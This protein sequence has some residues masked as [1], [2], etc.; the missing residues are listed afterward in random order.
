[1]R[2][3]RSGLLAEKCLCLMLFSSCTG[4]ASTIHHVAVEIGGFQRRN[5]GGPHV[6]VHE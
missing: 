1:M 3:A 5:L 4:L 6:G 2:P